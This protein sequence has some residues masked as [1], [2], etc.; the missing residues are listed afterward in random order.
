MVDRWR[1]GA[2]F[3]GAICEPWLMRKYLEGAAF[4]AMAVVV[5]ASTVAA[6]ALG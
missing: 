2:G 5:I 4:V 6:V 3:V 1:I